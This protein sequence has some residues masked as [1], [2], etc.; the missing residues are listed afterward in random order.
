MGTIW[1]GFVVALE[2]T[3]KFFWQITGQDAALAILLFTIA[4]KLVLL[5]LTASQ[6]RSTREMQKL[7]PKVR[8]LQ[9]R[10]KKDRQKLNEELM[11]LYREHGVNP[12]A[13]CLPSLLQ[14][15]IFFGVYFAILNLTRPLGLSTLLGRWVGFASA[16]YLG[17]GAIPADI[18]VGLSHGILANQTVLWMTS[19]GKPDPWHILPILAGVLQLL[20][21]KMMTP[22]DAD[23]QQAAMNNAMLFMPLMIVFIGWTFPAGPVLYWVIQSF[24]GIIQQYL[25]SGWGSLKD[26]LPFLP[27]RRVSERPRRASRERPTGEMPGSRFSRWMERI[28]RLQ[29]EAA[30]PEGLVGPEEGRTE[31]AGTPSLPPTPRKQR[32]SR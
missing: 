6:L 17:L 31:E 16:A 26:W 9:N 5:P 22:R 32:R 10:Y 25:T 27:E 4:V 12:A 11:K 21:Q 14:F 18:Q 30:R 7:Q 13:G 23:P 8:E 29:E 3:L 20:Q 28:F 19:L 2:E 24:L 1:N 15:P